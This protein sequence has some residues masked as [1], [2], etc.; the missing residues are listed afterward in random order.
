MTGA[1]RGAGTAYSPGAPEIS[2]NFSGVC[3]CHIVQ[4]HV[5]SS[6]LWGLLRFPVEMM[7]ASSLPSFVLHGC[8]IYGICIYLHK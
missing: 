1:N 7:F 5:V 3:I 2:P 8:F 4:L 6:V